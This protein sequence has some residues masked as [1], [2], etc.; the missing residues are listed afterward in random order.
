MKAITFRKN[1]ITFDYE[2]ACR[3]YS[4]VED[5]RLFNAGQINLG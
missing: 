4:S 3:V 2:T 1:G 5:N